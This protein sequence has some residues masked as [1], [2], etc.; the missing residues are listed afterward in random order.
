MCGNI[1]GNSQL[2][3]SNMKNAVVAVS[4]L[5]LIAS[6]CSDSPPAIAGPDVS[7]DKSAGLTSGSPTHE[8]RISVRGDGRI[9]SLH[10][11]RLRT[12]SGK[13]LPQRS[14]EQAGTRIGNTPP[15]GVHPQITSAARNSQ[16][17]LTVFYRA[18]GASKKKIEE[19]SPRLS[20]TTDDPPELPTDWDPNTDPYPEEIFSTVIDQAMTSLESDLN[21]ISAQTD[22]LLNDPYSDEMED[23]E[24]SEAG[25]LSVEG[26]TGMGYR[27]VRAAFS[28]NN[29]L[30][31][32]PCIDQRE[33][34]DSAL[35]ALGATAL[36][37]LAAIAAIPITAAGSAVA[38]IIGE[39]TIGFG[40]SAHSLNTATRAFARCKS[41]NPQYYPRRP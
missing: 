12:P 25:D 6:A 31:E 11:V 13:P 32:D 8:L 24:Y 23:E 10:T 28:L 37:G 40:A 30:E 22:D 4:A 33:A 39:A 41:R 35:V 1:I 21:S 14:T 27:F 5:A 26:T 19:I 18:T 17:L 2:R 16:N 3:G 36:M 34:V 38:F 7:L 20:A 9:A 29:F 15:A